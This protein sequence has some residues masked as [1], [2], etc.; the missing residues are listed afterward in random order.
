MLLFVVESRLL[1]KM[2]TRPLRAE[3]DLVYE[4]AKYTSTSNRT[5][6]GQHKSPA[7]FYTPVLPVGLL[8][9]D[10]VGDDIW[11]ERHETRGSPVPDRNSKP[12]PEM[13]HDPRPIDERR[14]E[15]R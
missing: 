2:A 12:I 8:S 11:H 4:M 5:G 3:I 9:T 1:D 14:A 7:L 6:N 10:A 15:W 13:D